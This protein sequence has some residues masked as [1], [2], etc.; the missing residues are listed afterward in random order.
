MFQMGRKKK[1]VK[2]KKVK[3]I[4]R[5]HVSLRV[6]EELYNQLKVV[7]E[8]LRKRGLIASRAWI[9][10]KLAEYGVTYFHRE[11]L[12]RPIINNL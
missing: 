8:E 6:S 7:Q 5:K 12:T 11:Y 4:K 3:K 2:K 10:L 9:L 1:K